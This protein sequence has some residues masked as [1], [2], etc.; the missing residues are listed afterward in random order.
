VI[1]QRTVDAIEA[2]DT[3]EL[4]RIVDGHCEARAWDS[5]AEMRSRCDEA[6]TRGKQ[7]WGVIEYI[8]YRFA[9]DAP[10]Q[11]AGPAV[12]GGEARFTL[13]PLP[14]VAASTKSWSDLDHHLSP[15]PARAMVAHERVVR[16]EDLREADVDHLVLELPLRL[17]PWEP[18]YRVPTY[19]H[20]RLELSTPSSPSISATETP[21]PSLEVDDL[22][23]T[24]ALLSLVD[25]WVQTSNGRAEAACVEGHPQAAIA[26]L[27]VA[28][29]GMRSVEPGVA[30][31]WM[32]WAAADGGA[33]GRRRG[34][35]LG[36][37]SAWW[38]AH[39]LSG[40]EWPAPPDELGAALSELDWFLWSDGSS[41]TGWALRLAVYSPGEGL[42]WAIRATDQE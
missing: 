35:A 7:L 2:S 42:A 15:G 30:L 22:E 18:A 24:R 32:A 3:D 16:G 37:F 38:T 26:A 5:L 19:H 28:R 21:S 10:G 33:H 36:R 29:M 27:G 40:L 39:E 41:P 1:D 13:G 12:D 20:D 17:Q 9:L 8:R 6:G 23:G 25:H 31:A 34:A 14:E 11:W 4:V